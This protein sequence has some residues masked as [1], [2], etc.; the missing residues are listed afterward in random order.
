MVSFSVTG[1]ED[2]NQHLRVTASPTNARTWAAAWISSRWTLATAASTAAA[3]VSLPAAAGRRRALS[4]SPSGGGRVPSRPGRRGKAG[5]PPE[6][7]FPGPP[8]SGPGWQPGGPLAEASAAPAAPPQLAV[9]SPPIP[10]CGS[11]THPRGAEAA[12]PLRRA[13]SAPAPSFR[14]L[15]A[16]EAGRG[17]PCS[18]ELRQRWAQAC[19]LLPPLVL[20]SRGGRR[21][22]RGRFGKNRQLCSGSGQEGEREQGPP[23][24]DQAPG[25]GQGALAALQPPPRV[26][27]D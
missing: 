8:P 18:E 10:A 3:Q 20:G 19:P 9:L 21:P 5:H 14:A 13:S 25:T 6:A 16:G 26:K 22:P 4:G 1:A 7:S 2:L 17:G 24:G 15:P 23:W 27:L 12:R 11:P